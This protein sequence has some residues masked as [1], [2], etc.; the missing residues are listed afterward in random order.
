VREKVPK[1]PSL[2]E[3]MKNVKQHCGKFAADEE[4]E[5]ENNPTIPLVD[6][7]SSCRI[8]VPA[9]FQACDGLRCF[10]MD[11]FLQMAQRSR[12]WLCP[13]CLAEGHPETIIIDTFLLSI[14]RQLDRE[15]RS[16]AIEIEIKEDASW[17][18][19]TVRALR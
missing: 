1:S 6:P 16:D 2:D 18:P 3:C 8:A 11:T 5:V 9:R 4:M 12:K 17:R 13:H 7:I 10:D 14:L 19:I 15:G